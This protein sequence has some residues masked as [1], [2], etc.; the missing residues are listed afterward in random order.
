MVPDFD[1]FNVRV[2]RSTTERI[3]TIIPPA[4]T[5]IVLAHVTTACFKTVE[6]DDYISIAEIGSQGKS[7]V[8]CFVCP[9]RICFNHR[10]AVD[11]DVK[12]EICRCAP[13]PRGLP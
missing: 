4:V 7:I 13:R 1:G 3:K 9:F 12:E 8:G 10:A 6:V 11:G 2:A 5:F